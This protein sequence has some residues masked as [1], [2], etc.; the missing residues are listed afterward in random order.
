MA[1]LRYNALKTGAAGSGVALSLGASLTSSAT[2]ITFN[3]ALTHSNGT[4]VPTIVSPD[5]IP[6]EILDSSGNMLEIVWLT[7]YTAAATTGTIAR[8]KE[9]TTGVAHSS[10]DKIVHGPN[11]TDISDVKDRR[12]SAASTS[13]SIDE[14]NDESLDSAW[15]RVDG[16]GAA[17]GNC[18]WTESGDVLS[19]LRK[20]ANTGNAMNAIV[21]PIGT[22]PATGD[23]W[24]TCV[25]MFGPPSTN[26][27]VNGIIIS[28]G[29]THGAGKQVTAGAISA[30]TPVA[31]LASSAET[32]TNF[33]TFGTAATVR[34]V[35]FGVPTF[36]RL[37]YMGSSQWRS[38]TS[39]DGVL[40][41]LG[42][43]LVTQ[44]SFTPSHVGVYS[45]DGASGT[46]WVA[47]FE[48]L[49]RVSGVS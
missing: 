40:W 33:G 26:Y 27:V 34:N 38:D 2:S 6:L 14:F 13:T 44:S 3:A 7:A 15:V 9:G 43:S 36:L 37:V 22:A 16:T 4:A 10:G 31:T 30:A 24:I 45:R 12:W 17:S 5:Y 39:P 8:G 48:F 32:W 42:A 41:M 11:V 49:R 29:T 35:P 20:A 21:R 28:D 18:D 25:T 47:S 19:M 46:I 23:A 1:R